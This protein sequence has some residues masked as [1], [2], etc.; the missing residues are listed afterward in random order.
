MSRPSAI[1]E[2]YRVLDELRRA[3]GDVPLGSCNGRRKWPRR[4]VYLFFETGELRAD[5]ETP[6]VVRVG[7]HAVSKGSSATLWAAFERIAVVAMDEETT[8]DRYFATTLEQ[9]F[10]APGE[11]PPSYRTPGTPR[12]QPHTSAQSRSHSSAW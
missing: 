8:A 11:L 5:G 10:F 1:D 12:P 7:T 9:P 2:L 6:R 4:G 3:L